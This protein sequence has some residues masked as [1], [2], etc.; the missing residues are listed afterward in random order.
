METSKRDRSR[1]LTW[2]YCVL[3]GRRASEFVTREHENYDYK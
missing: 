3:G 1:F 2:P